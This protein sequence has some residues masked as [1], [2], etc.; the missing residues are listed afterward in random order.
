MDAFFVWNVGLCLDLKKKMHYGLQHSATLHGISI[1]YVN[2]K[3]PVYTDVCE[4]SVKG[5]HCSISLL[6]YSVH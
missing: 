1:Q 6:M 3:T 4:L 2:V 5:L